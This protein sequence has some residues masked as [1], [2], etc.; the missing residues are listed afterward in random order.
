MFYKSKIFQIENLNNLRPN[1]SS[2]IDKKGAIIL[3]ETEVGKSN[4]E[5]YIIE[6][7]TLK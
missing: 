6:K 4:F 1:S 7:K 2:I 5:N 3:D